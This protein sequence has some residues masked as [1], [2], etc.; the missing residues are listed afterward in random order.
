MRILLISDIHSNWPAL[1]AVRETYDMC[2]CLGDLVDY[3]V[4]PTPCIDWVRRNAAHCVRGN[5]DHGSAQGVAVSGI[6]GFRYLTS[7][8][9]PITC[10][11]LSEDDRRYLSRLPLT[12]Y[13]SLNGKRYLV[14]HAT[15]RDPMD[16]YAPADV[17]FWKRRLEGIDVDYVVC[18]HTH[19]PYILHVGNTTVVNPG[20]I[21][22]PRDGDPRASYAIIADN[23]IEM[24]RVEYP[25]ERS[26]EAVMASELPQKAKE[27][28][29]E[30][31]RTGRL[32]N[33][34]NGS[35]K[36]NGA[37]SNGPVKTELVSEQELSETRVG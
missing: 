12:K 31:Y 22:L 8:S 9:R 36:L 29:A 32:V 17:D 23:T 18:G 33:G 20:S 11:K 37:G 25:T 24:K 14:I 4:E 19:Q 15:P 34:K 26:I 21:G 16:E 3:G 30:V 28:L 27:M 35:F 6:G 1:E 10:S 2:L 5:H 7:V 13:L